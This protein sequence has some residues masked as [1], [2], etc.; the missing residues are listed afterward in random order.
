VVLEG[1]SG[2]SAQDSPPTTYLPTHPPLPPSLPPSP[3]LRLEIFLRAKEY[4]V[5]FVLLGGDLFHDN[6]PSRKTMHSTISILRRHCLG[7]DPVSFQVISEPPP[8]GGTE[9]TMDGMNKVG[10]FA[11]VN[12]EDPNYAVGLPIFSIHGNHDDPSRDG[13]T[14]PLSAMDLLSVT[15]LVNYF[16]KAS[17]TD[18]VEVSPLLLRKGGTLMALYGLG[19][20]RDERLNRMWQ[21]K[22]IRFLRHRPTG[23]D[24]EQKDFFSLFALH[25]NRDTGRGQ[26]NCVQESMIP[27]WMDL[28][29]WGYVK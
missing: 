19:N 9:G 25:Q 22:K 17:A 3:F 10:N 13:N 18:N 5:D 14:E 24:E 21:K 28:V 16:G 8:Q 4:H 12:Y 26:K 15:N 27:E 7:D 11:H 29:V 23:R 20:M 1:I 2:S 6:K